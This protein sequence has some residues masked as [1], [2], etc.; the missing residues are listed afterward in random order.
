MASKGRTDAMKHGVPMIED[1]DF[2]FA[3]GWLSPDGHY[4][5]CEYG[6]HI[7]LAEKLA[8]KYGCDGKRKCLSDSK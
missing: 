6:Q 2:Q 4:F 5:G 8:R 7:Y 3:T 1:N